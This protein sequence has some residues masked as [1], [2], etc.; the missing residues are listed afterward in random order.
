M[1]VVFKRDSRDRRNRLERCGAGA[2][3]IGAWRCR[4]CA[5]AQRQRRQR[6]KG[7]RALPIARRRGC[8]GRHGPAGD[9]G[10]GAEGN[11]SRD[12]HLL[13]DPDD[14]RSPVVIHRCRSAG[15]FM[16]SYFRQVPSIVNRGEMRLPMADARIASIDIGDIADVAAD[17]M[18]GSGHE[19]KTYPITGPDALT[20]TE[21]ATELSTATG[22]PI[23]Y[24]DVPPED[25]RAAQIAAG[26]PP[27]LADGLA[28]LFAERR[29]GK[30]ATVSP[31]IPTVFKR[32]P[33]SFADFA[34]RHAAI[35]RGEQPAP[36][37]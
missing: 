3:A 29:K 28:E 19:G 11:R 24:V 27:Y 9:A 14:E 1:A 16:H 10:V 30:E 36:R 2:K 26:M 22:K 13:L 23:R 25:A 33:M 4:P 34:R 31:V 21:V 37:V 15:E 35:F 18:T 17:V 20:M 32:R 5:G 7:R 8:R 6:G 12:A